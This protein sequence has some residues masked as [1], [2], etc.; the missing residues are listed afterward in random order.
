MPRWFFAAVLVAIAPRAG[1]AQA[2]P[3]VVVSAEGKVHADARAFPGGPVGEAPGLD[4]RRARVEVTAEVGGWLRA[5]VEPDVGQGEVE[6]KDGFAEA[7]LWTPGARRLAVRVGQFKTPAGYESLRS[8]S[9]LRFAERALPTAL[10]PR[11]DL[12]A[13]ATWDA[14]RLEAQAGVFNGVPDGG[15]PDGDRGSTALD[16]AARVFAHP[17][18]PLA[19][20]GLGA[21]VTAGTDRGTPDD[22]G[23]DD[24]ETAGDRTV[25]AFADGI[26]TDGTRLRLLPQAT[27]DVGRL[28]VLGEWALARHELAGPDGRVSVQHRAWQAAASVV[29]VGVPQGDG[30]PVPERSVTEGGPGAVEVSARLHRL[31]LD[32]RV[33]PLAADGSARRAR[34][35]GVAVH[36]SPVAEARVGLTAERTVFDAFELEPPPPDET[37]VVLRAQIDL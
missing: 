25:F 23:L 12:G 31:T 34:A 18:G 26:H 24:Y 21:A 37:L 33:G 29:L 28:H 16:A 14:P 3:S 5:V 1:T 20:L 7:D 36:W 22:A 19:G 35:L 10:S 6:L 32:D 11:R 15:S 17:G 30:R 4:L 8:S 27:L 9:D 2:P 13:L